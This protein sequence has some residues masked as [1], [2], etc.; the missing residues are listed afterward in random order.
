[1]Q[2]GVGNALMALP[3]ALAAALVGRFGRRPALTHALWLLVLVKL[4]TPPLLPLP[5]PWL[6]DAL[7]ALAT[8]DVTPEPIQEPAPAPPE[9]GEPAL[10]WPVYVSVVWLAGTAACFGV[11]LARIGRFQRLLRHTR[12]APPDLQ[13]EADELARRMGAAA[14]P[15]VRLVPGLLAPMLWSFG[16]CTCLLMPAAL[17]GRLDDD[18][19]R[20]LLAHELAHW[21][22]RDHWV[23]Y[24][25]LVVLALYWW[26]PL[27]WLARRRLR[28]AEEECC[29]AWVMWLLPQAGR[30][31][32]TALVETLDFLA[33]ARP[34]LPP[35]ASGIGQFTLMRKRLTLI[36]SGTPPR[37]LPVAGLL[38]VGGLGLLLLPVAPGFAGPAA[39]GETGEG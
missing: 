28:D 29:D 7:P 10:P 6:T 12:Q 9:V 5:L 26:L 39:P 11:A 35:A 16:R 25:E 1:L 38:A 4:V 31:Y 36:L 18:Q 37:S 8:A 22:R 19:R 15:R 30:A 27:A 14:G 2:L 13:A 34:S 32:A 21:R 3:L 23:R 17:L 33:Q 24:L 20:T